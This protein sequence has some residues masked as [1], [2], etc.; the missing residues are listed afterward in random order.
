MPQV[1]G[2][3]SRISD[4]LRSSSTKY[5]IE[6]RKRKLLGSRTLTK[7][8]NV[9]MRKKGAM[10]GGGCYFFLN[11]LKDIYSYPEAVHFVYRKILRNRNCH[12]QAEEGIQKWFYGILAS[13]QLV[14]LTR[15][16]SYC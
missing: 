13:S 14:L 6:L 2:P 8:N 3:L 16:R 1:Y 9:T 15:L 7:V 11:S 5:E 4:D 10:M 12:R